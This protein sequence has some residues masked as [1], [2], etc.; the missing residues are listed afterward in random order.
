MAAGWFKALSLRA[1]RLGVSQP[2]VID[3]K[4][5]PAAC[6]Q[7]SPSRVRFPKGLDGVWT[8]SYDAAKMARTQGT[9]KQA[10]ELYLNQDHT[11]LAYIILISMGQSPANYGRGPYMRQRAIRE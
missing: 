11:F 9:A 3:P 5:R 7:S 4:H 6:D 2:S 1:G 8:E 10:M